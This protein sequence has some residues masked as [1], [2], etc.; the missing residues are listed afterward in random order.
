MSQALHVLE[1]D[2]RADTHALN[3]LESYSGSV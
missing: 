1:R 3:C 2:P